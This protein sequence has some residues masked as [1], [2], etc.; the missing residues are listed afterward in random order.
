MFSSHMLR[1]N[2]SIE[3]LRLWVDIVGLCDILP[4]LVL[5]TG[6][7]SVGEKRH[8]SKKISKNSIALNLSGE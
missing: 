2:V 5:K 8:R 4:F 3:I 6:N 7:L 1:R